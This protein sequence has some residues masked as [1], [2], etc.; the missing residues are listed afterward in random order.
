MTFPIPRLA[1]GRFITA[2]GPATATLRAARPSVVQ[3]DDGTR[4]R[5]Y[6]KAVPLRELAV[7]IVCA[8][9][10]DSLG[11][12][13]AR[14]ILVSMP[15]GDPQYGATI[16]PA[17]PFAHT[18]ARDGTA[19][20]RLR[21]WPHLTQAVC[22]DEWI[23]NPDRNGGNILHDGRDKFWLIDHG[24]AAAE[25]VAAD[26]TCTNTL[27]EIAREGLDAATL[28]NQFKPRLRTVIYG[29]TTATID[30]LAAEITSS[31][32]PDAVAVLGFLTTR[33][34]Q[35]LNLIDLRIPQ[36]QQGIFD[37]TGH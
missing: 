30:A 13:G 15:R 8:L 29:Y 36:G 19:R 37:D 23:A 35:L 26:A 3:L 32:L 33:H 10:L 9:L 1:H 18:L 21:T 16:L 20:A 34:A 11:L 17:A 27:F 31:S 22:F 6:V 28:T 12:P 2:V 5:A 25:G 24:L 14:P 7:E 4:V